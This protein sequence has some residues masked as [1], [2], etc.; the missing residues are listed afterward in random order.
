MHLV[1]SVWKDASRNY[2]SLL[3]SVLTVLLYSVS[4][5]PF[6]DIDRSFQQSL[7]P[8]L[9]QLR[10]M[11]DDF[12]LAHSYGLFRRMTGV[13]GRPEVVVEG[14]VFKMHISASIN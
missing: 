12:E 11:T 3:T 13:G 2:V 5:V 9:H 6:A 14:R 4:I 1:W 8:Q 7:P 10:A